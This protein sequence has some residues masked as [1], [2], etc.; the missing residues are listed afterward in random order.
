V[1]Q[2]I[3]GGE[4]CGYTTKIMFLFLQTIFH[5]ITIAIVTVSVAIGLISAPEPPKQPVLD[6]QSSVA[7]EQQGKE[8]E[9]QVQKKQSE[10]SA[11]TETEKLKKEIESL[12]KNIGQQNQS[13]AVV[14]QSTQQAPQP[15]VQQTVPLRPENSDD[16]TFNWDTWAWEKHP[17]VPPVA[18]TVSF[19]QSNNQTQTPTQNIQNQNTTQPITQNQPQTK[20]PITLSMS[21]IIEPIVITKDTANTFSGTYIDNIKSDMGGWTK[22]TPYIKLFGLH[23]FEHADVRFINPKIKLEPASFYVDNLGGINGQGG[24]RQIIAAE[25]YIN[26]STGRVPVGVYDKGFKYTYASGDYQRNV[27]PYQLFEVP[28]GSAVNLN[29]FY[30]FPELSS[31]NN[32]GK[33]IL[34]YYD[35]TITLK[36]DRVEIYKCDEGYECSLSPDLQQQPFSISVSPKF[37]IQ[38]KKPTGF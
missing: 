32:D 1:S 37:I 7:A 11:S 10:D 28:Y 16:W 13:S 25:G 29:N 4:L 9:L 26:F 15:K 34:E 24:T 12:R 38:E 5:K 20:I 22:Y 18:P 6:K 27:G 23:N 33:N 14:N 17:S 35:S 3:A 31:K 36:A 8:P 21:V 19:P 30:F 2:G